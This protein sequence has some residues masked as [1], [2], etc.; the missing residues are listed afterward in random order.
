MMRIVICAFAAAVGAAAALPVRAQTAP[1]L[2]DLKVVAEKSTSFEELGAGNQNGSGGNHNG[3]RN[4]N[5]GGYYGYGG[6]GY[7]GYYWARPQPTYTNG[8]IGDIDFVDDS[9]ITAQPA[10]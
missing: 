4:G 6:F 8:A 5:K 1:S 2:A 9:E 10:R 7:Y 3:N